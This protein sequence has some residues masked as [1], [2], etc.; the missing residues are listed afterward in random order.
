MQFIHLFAYLF[1][2]CSIIASSTIFVVQQNTLFPPPCSIP[3][4]H[5]EQLSLSFFFLLHASAYSFLSFHA[6]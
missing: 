5:A 2:H 1:M 4:H 3:L 6:M